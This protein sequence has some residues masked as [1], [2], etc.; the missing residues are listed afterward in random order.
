MLT[1]I[2]SFSYKALNVIFYFFATAT[3]TSSLSHKQEVAL[4]YMCSKVLKNNGESQKSL[5]FRGK[6][7]G[8]KHHVWKYVYI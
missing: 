8:L 7:I 4:D 2:F 5:E 1:F 6:M 3:H